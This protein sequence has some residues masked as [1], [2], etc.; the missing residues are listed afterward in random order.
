MS[1]QNYYSKRKERQ[2]REL[3]CGV[4]VE[5]TRREKSV[6]PMLGGRKC[7]RII[8]PELSKQG[9]R[10]GRDRYFDIL[11]E[12]GMLVKRRRSK[13]KT[14]NSRHSLP[15]FKNLMSGFEPKSP[16]EAW[17]SDITYID[18]EEGFLYAAL[19]TDAYSRKI[20]GCSIGDSLEAEGAISALEM[21]KKVFPKMPIRYII[22]TEVLS[23]AVINILTVCRIGSR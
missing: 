19:V 10:I 20:V 22:P 15:V 18:T 9:I 21:A 14:T 5:L 6:Q 12:N 23:I 8:S 16:N 17:V 2:K 3:D 7:L 1:P 4:V 11:R 13:P